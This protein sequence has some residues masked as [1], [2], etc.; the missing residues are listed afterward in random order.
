V[1][2]DGFSDQAELERRVNRLANERTALF[3]KAGA[4][5]GLSG[6]DQ[7]RLTAVERELDECFLLRRQAR[8]DRDARRFGRDR[9]PTGVPT[10]RKAP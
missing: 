3:D 9:L 4:T 5:F 1:S 8:A 2:T 7:A 10:P 6:P